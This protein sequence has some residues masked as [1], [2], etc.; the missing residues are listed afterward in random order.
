MA[1]AAAATGL[2]ALPAS[3]P[4]TGPLA[5]LPSAEGP[6]IAK[7]R[8]LAGGAWLDLGEPAPDPKWGHG[9]GRA[10]C[11]RM[12]FAPRLRGAFHTGEGVHAFV[13]PDG[14]YMDDFFFYD[15]NAHAWVCVYPG[16]KAGKDQGLKLNEDGF[17]VNAAGDVIPPG[18]LAHNYDQVAYDTHTQKLAFIPK[19]GASGWWCTMRLDQVKALAPAANAK[20]KGKTYGPWLLDARTGKFRRDEVK[21]PGVNST[22]GAGAMVY[23][24]SIRKFFVRSTGRP[25]N[26]LYDPAGKTRARVAACPKVAMGSD[27]ISGYDAKRGRVYL[28][29]GNAKG[30]ESLLAYDPAGDRWTELRPVAGGGKRCTGNSA[31]M[32]YDTVNDVLIVALYGGETGLYV[33]DPKTDTWSDKP[34]AFPPKWARATTGAFCDT[35]NNVHYYYQARDSHPQGRVFVYRHRRKA[36]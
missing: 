28:A 22:T 7:I 17:F 24:A 14:R 25:G 19:G 35:V 20:M 18:L 10:W 26:W 36:E 11:A 4:A 23:V 31:S 3:A 15:L 9:R 1:L 13:K 8:A 27:T 30:A 2:G 34:V 21:G 29:G 5:K 33:Y 32:T 12:N 16:A 6:H